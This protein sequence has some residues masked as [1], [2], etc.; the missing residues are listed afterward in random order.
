MTI[1]VVIYVVAF[2]GITIVLAPF[3]SWMRP[4][5]NTPPAPTCVLMLMPLVHG[6]LSSGYN[7]CLHMAARRARLSLIL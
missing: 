2:Q 5:V 6:P 4:K 3:R 1:K 7:Y